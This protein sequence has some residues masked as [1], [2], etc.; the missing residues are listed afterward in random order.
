MVCVGGVRTV[1]SMDAE[2]DPIKIVE[3][4]G[5]SAELKAEQ[6]KISLG[7]GEKPPGEVPDKRKGNM[8]EQWGW[9]Y[10]FAEVNGRGSNGYGHAH[11]REDPNQELSYSQ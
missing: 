1:D 2:S 10:G 11:A 8:Y 3:W 7:R 5:K 9:T 6:R 4:P